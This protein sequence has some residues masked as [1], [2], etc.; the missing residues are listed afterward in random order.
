MFYT[1]TKIVVIGS[2]VRRKAGPRVGS[3]GFIVSINPGVQFQV[4]YTNDISLRLCLATVLFTKYG[5]Q[6]SERAE[7]KEIALILPDAR[8][9]RSSTNKIIKETKKYINNYEGATGIVGKKAVIMA[10]PTEYVD[11]SML[12]YKIFC[13][14]F[15]LTTRDK[16]NKIVTI[17]NTKQFPN[18]IKLRRSL[19]DKAIA[20]LI[21]FFVRVRHP[22]VYLKHILLEDVAVLEEVLNL[23]MKLNALKYIANPIKANHWDTPDSWLFKHAFKWFEYRDYFEKQYNEERNRIVKH[24]LVCQAIQLEG[25]SLSSKNK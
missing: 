7:L 4:Q 15:N 3:E 6:K 10:A 2:N 9:S 25:L 14:L 8:N 13:Y 21:K 11:A 5:F 16:L 18:V 19:S 24:A 23:V 20:F 17:N 22:Q 12:H 1:S